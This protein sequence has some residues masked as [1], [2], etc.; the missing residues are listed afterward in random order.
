MHGPCRT[1][2][3]ECQLPLTVLFDVEALAKPRT[4][5]VW[6]CPACGC[7]DRLLTQFRVVKV[8]QGHS[9]EPP[10]VARLQRARDALLRFWR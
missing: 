3:P 10:R 2:C 6:V 7:T 1:Y 4:E 9:S 8:W 5:R